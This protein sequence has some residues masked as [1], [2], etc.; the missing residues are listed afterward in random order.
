MY[1]IS[2]TALAI[3]GLVAI[4]FFFSPVL[5]LVLLVLAVL[6]IGAAKFLT[7]G[8]RPEAAAP[9]SRTS[10]PA[11][12]PGARETATGREDE[13]TGLWG[14]KWPEQRTEAEERARR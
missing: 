8:A 4:G 9:P 12:A 1:G 3:V 10:P 7:Q 2:I 14:E 13:D 11:N 6:A 5:A